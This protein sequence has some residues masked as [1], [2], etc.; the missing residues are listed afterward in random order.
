LLQDKVY[1]SYGEA[2]KIAAINRGL[3]QVFTHKETGVEVLKSNF[4]SS[5]ALSTHQKGRLM[6]NRVL[7]VKGNETRA[8]VLGVRHTFKISAMGELLHKIGAD[9]VY[10]IATRHRYTTMSWVR[11]NI[12][13]K[14][15][16]AKHSRI[17][18][19][20]P[21][22]FYTSKTFS[23]SLTPYGPLTSIT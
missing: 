4:S 7:G 10:L 19:T 15:C 13:H 23:K 21:P 22:S 5:V 20:K 6:Q 14:A 2:Q 12:T 8:T 17:T 18:S 9:Q 1:S 11:V 3:I 16:Q